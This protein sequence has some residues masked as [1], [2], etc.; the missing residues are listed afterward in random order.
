M[1]APQPSLKNL[2]RSRMAHIGAARGRAMARNRP[3]KSAS[4]SHS[5]ASLSASHRQEVKTMRHTVLALAVLVFAAPP[6]PRGL[7]A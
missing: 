4:P 2:L 7:N 6:R 3:T 5:A 1:S